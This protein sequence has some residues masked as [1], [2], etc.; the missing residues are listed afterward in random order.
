[1][2]LTNKYNSLKCILIKLCNYRT[3]RFN[4]RTPRSRDRS[5][6]NFVANTNTN[7]NTYKLN[8]LKK[9]KHK[10]IQVKYT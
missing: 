9:H 5:C 7:T 4:Y 2:V 8:I 6:Y 10:H 1:M 3:P